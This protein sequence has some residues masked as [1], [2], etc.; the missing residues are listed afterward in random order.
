MKRRDIN[1]WAIELASTGQ[2][3]DWR[4]VELEIRKQ[5]R[6]TLKLNDPFWK[7]EVDKACATSRKDADA[8]RT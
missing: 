2:F 7:G 8:N 6:S 4:A 1:S 5:S 3:R